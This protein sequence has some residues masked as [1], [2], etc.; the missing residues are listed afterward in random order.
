MG[1]L[2]R[3]MMI[4]LRRSGYDQAR[5]RRYETD[6]IVRRSWDSFRSNMGKLYVYCGNT[7]YYREWRWNIDTII[8]RIHQIEPSSLSYH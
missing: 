3:C 4:C 5:F 1:G 8:Y 7:Q 2:V 6:Y